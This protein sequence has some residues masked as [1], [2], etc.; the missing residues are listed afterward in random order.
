MIMSFCDD[1]AWRITWRD[2]FDGPHLDATKW[3]VQRGVAP[4]LPPPPPFSPRQPQVGRLEADC[5]G[6]QCASLGSC[7]EAACTEDSVSLR[8]GRLVLTSVR[9]QA[10]HRNYTTGAVNT[11]GKATWRADA[12]DN[13]PFRMCISA[14]LPGVPGRSTGVWPA[15]WLMPATEACDPDEG[16]MD[17]ME[18]VDGAGHTYSTYHWQTGYPRLK[19][20][21]PHNHSHVY[22]LNDLGDDWNV[23]FH[24]WAVERR[25]DEIAFAVDGKE[26]LRTKKPL[27]WDVPWYLILNTAIGGGWPGSPTPDTSFPI[28]HEIEYVRVARPK[29]YRA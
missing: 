4:G 14:Q 16:E 6:P 1:P 8:D 12:H 9:R 26:T 15:H 20:A 25:A 2:E 10:M 5:H 24:E 3:T 13:G 18:M 21:F 23:T 29:A 11:L 19:C 28:T 22:A 7:R 17:V 27:F